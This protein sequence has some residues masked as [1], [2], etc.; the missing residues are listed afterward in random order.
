MAAENVL[1]LLPGNQLFV[2]PFISHAKRQSACL[3]LFGLSA[4]PRDILFR[5]SRGLKLAMSVRACV[6]VC[7][8]VGLYACVCVKHVCVFLKALITS[9]S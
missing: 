2:Y 6:C 5:R 9:A 3:E 1:Q 4:L 8:R 7:V